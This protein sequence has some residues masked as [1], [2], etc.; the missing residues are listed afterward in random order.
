MSMQTRTTT[1]VSSGSTNSTHPLGLKSQSGKSQI[2]TSTRVLPYQSMVKECH[3][4]VV[5]VETYPAHF[6]PT[7]SDIRS[8]AFSPDDRFLAI[9]GKDGIIRIQSIIDSIPSSSL[10]VISQEPDIQSNDAALLSWKNNQLETTDALLTTTI[11]QSHSPSHHALASRAVIRA[12]LQKWDAAVKDAEMAIDIQPSI[13]AFM[14][15]SVAHV[16]NG[17]KDKGY[18]TCD[19]AFEHF[20]SSHVTFLLLIKVCI[21]STWLPLGRSSFLGY[22]RVYGRRTHRCDIP[23]RRPHCYGPLQ[24][25][26]LYGPGIHAS[27]TWMLTHAAQ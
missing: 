6:H 1:L 20:H 5:H 26:V 8:I 10:Q 4:L 3:H 23:F 22:H 18:R 11:S 12:R 19:I 25:G 13:I 15:K 7:H 2:A 27:S 14:A 16:G 9:G 24:L 21:F 17:D